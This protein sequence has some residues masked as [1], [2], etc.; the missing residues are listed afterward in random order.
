M[1]MSDERRQ[2]PRE[3]L[4]T[5]GHDLEAPRDVSP[6]AARRDLSRFA[7]SYLS[8]WPS[9]LAPILF[10]AIGAWQALTGDAAAPSMGPPAT[11]FGC[12][13]LQD[14]SDRRPAVPMASAKT[15]GPV[16]E[17]R[18]SLAV[19]ARG[20]PA[21]TLANAVAA[22]LLD[23]RGLGMGSCDLRDRIEHGGLH[24][25]AGAVAAGGDRRMAAT[26]A[27]DACLRFK[28]WRCM[29]VWATKDGETSTCRIRINKKPRG[30]ALSTRCSIHL[31]PTRSG[32]TWK[33]SRRT[34]RA[35]RTRTSAAC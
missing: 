25:G 26:S 23:P 3:K 8:S 15:I 17:V 29:P 28:G 32:Q 18:A 27:T 24:A 9:L 13:G 14:R 16:G 19:I 35:G 4:E 6:A 2:D 7:G 12:L 33:P 30:R 5:G 10:I 1:V 11:A 34:S 22:P 20:R 21:S 31:S